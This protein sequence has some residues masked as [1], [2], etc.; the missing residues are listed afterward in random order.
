[1]D[2]RVEEFLDDLGG[3]REVDARGARERVAELFPQMI[4]EEDRVAL[5][6]AF[7]A[8]MG[9]AVRTVSKAGR[10]T[11]A[12]EDAIRADRRLFALQEAMGDG[13]LVDPTELHRVIQRE[14]AAGR[15]QEDDY[16]DLARSGAAVLGDMPQRTSKPGLFSRLFGR[17]R[18]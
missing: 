8:V 2:A 11:T 15:M 17:R 12:L 16:A 13:E 3:Q 7:H 6:Q 1:M 9:L 5:L 18:A 10:D 4:H 14:I